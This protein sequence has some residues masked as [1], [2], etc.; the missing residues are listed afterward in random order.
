MKTINFTSLLIAVFFSLGITP[1]NATSLPYEDYYSSY[2]GIGVDSVQA[3]PNIPSNDNSRYDGPFEDYY[4]KYYVD[5]QSI[6]SNSE[7]DTLIE[8]VTDPTNY[9]KW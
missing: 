8:E 4:N 5:T 3:T 6:N 1:A 9:F 7:I 2:Y